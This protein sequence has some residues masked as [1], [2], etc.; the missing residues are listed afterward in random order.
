[1]RHDGQTGSTPL[2][3]EFKV[4]S[5]QLIT[6][7]GPGARAGRRWEAEPPRRRRRGREGF[8]GVFSSSPALLEG[9]RPG[10]FFYSLSF[11]PTFQAYFVLHLNELLCK[12]ALFSLKIYFT[13]I[14]RFKNQ[15]LQQ[16]NKKPHII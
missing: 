8:Q 5:L 3:A 13:R 16:F 14:G 7:E 15:K 2:K 12:H 1:M 9:S 10:V 6:E 4:S 11:Q